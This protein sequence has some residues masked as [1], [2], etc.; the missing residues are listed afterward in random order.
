MNT[1]EEFYDEISKEYT[2]SVERCVPMYREMLSMLFAFLPEGYAPKTILELGCGAGNLTTLIG[3]RFPQAKIHAVDISEECIKECRQRLPEA[4]IEY[5]KAD[6]SNLDFPENT[7]DLIISSISIHHLNDSEKEIFFKR[8]F[9]WQTTNGILSF[10][11]QFRG[12][13]E[14][15]YALH[16][17]MWKTFAREQGASAKE[18]DLWME[19]QTQHD[20]HAPLF[21]HVTWLK[22]AGYGMVDCVWRYLL[23]AVIYSRKGVRD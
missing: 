23:W 2:D 5:I 15:L 4:D 12:E 3:K 6:F 16:M 21:R 1:I 7:F 9:L 10:C 13:S 19:H 11:D 18:W 8:L 17:E 14:R 20:C 22:D